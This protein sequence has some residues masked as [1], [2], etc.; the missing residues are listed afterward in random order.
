LH[1]GVYQRLP[2][3]LLVILGDP[4][5]GKTAAM[6]LLL[7]A[8]LDHRGRLIGEQ[9]RRTPVPVWLIGGGVRPRRDLPDGGQDRPGR[10]AAEASAARWPRSGA[11][12]AGPP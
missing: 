6:I 10:T 1:E 12:I 9:R 5:A 3:R 11:T 2:H 8:A 4:G 7:L